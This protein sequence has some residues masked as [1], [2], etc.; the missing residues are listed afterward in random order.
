MG[1]IIHE[2]LKASEG[3]ELAESARAEQ[4]KII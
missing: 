2:V 3:L 4:F 1:I